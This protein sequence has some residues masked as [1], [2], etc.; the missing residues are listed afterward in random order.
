MDINTKAYQPIVQLIRWKNVLK[1]VFLILAFILQLTHFAQEFREL[2][3]PTQAVS[4]S[5]K[6]LFMLKQGLTF[7]CQFLITLSDRSRKQ[8]PKKSKQS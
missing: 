7:N 1:R 5:Q 3:P 4:N 8:K 2:K 6:V